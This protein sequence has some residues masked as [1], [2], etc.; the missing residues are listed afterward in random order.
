M[1]NPCPNP[2]GDNVNTEMLGALSDMHCKPT[3]LVYEQQTEENSSQDIVYYQTVT[4][5]HLFYFNY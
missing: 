1:N 3:I 2:Q 4:L 5:P